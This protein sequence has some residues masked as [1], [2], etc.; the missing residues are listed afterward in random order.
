V[1]SNLS[2]SINVN[3]RCAIVRS[4]GILSALASGVNTFMLKQNAGIWPNALHY[5]LMDGSLE[6]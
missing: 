6:S 5:L 1:P 2:A 3:N 4:L